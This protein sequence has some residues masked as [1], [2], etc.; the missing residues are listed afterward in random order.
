M[1]IHFSRRLVPSLVS[2]SLIISLL[3]PWPLQA[4]ARPQNEPPRA[5]LTQSTSDLPPYEEP[6]APDP[7]PEPLSAP[8]VDAPDREGIST[9]A[10]PEDSAE[11]RAP[12]PAPMKHG[13]LYFSQDSNTNGLYLVDTV[14]GAATLVGQSGVTASTVGLA[15]GPTDGTL[16]GSKWAGLL[17]IAR[18]GSGATL[19]GSVGMEGMAYLRGTLYASINFEFFTVDTTTGT[20]Y[21]TLAAPPFDAE[22]L[23]AD[24]ERNRVYGIGQDSDLLYY[25][26]VPSNAWYVVGSTGVPSVPGWD[27][28]ALAYDP[29]SRELY[30]ASSVMGGN[31]YRINPT[32]AARTLVGNMG[33][34][35]AGGGLAYVTAGQAYVAATWADDAVHI[36]DPGMRDLGKFNARVAD[37]NAVVT[38]GELVYTGHYTT[39]EVIATDFTGSE[40]FRWPVD[41]PG[42]AGM[43]LVDGTLAVL[44]QATPYQVGIYQ[45]RTG[46]LL[47]SY[48]ALPSVE[49]LAYDGTLL[50]QLGDLL[51]GTD[52]LDGHVVR[53]LPNAASGCSFGGTGLAAAPPGRLTLSCSNGNWYQISADTGVVLASGDNDLSIYGLDA[54]PPAY[55]AAHWAGDEVTGLD[56]YMQPL[57]RMSAGATEPNGAASDGR[58]VYTGH[59]ESEHIIGHDLAGTERVR[60]SAAL[61]GLQGMDMVYGALAIYRSL[62]EPVIQ[63]RRA[64]TGALLRTVPG[65]LSVEGLAFDGELLWQL[66]NANV[67][68]SRPSD[69]AVV[70]TVPNPAAACLFGGTALTSGPPGQLIAGCSDGRWFRFSSV[71]GTVLA[72][73]HLWPGMYGLATL[74]QPP[75]PVY[76][77]LVMR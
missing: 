71:N 30:A 16:Y 68:G 25:Y 61:D 62:S 51:Y 49:A 23:A 18:D 31:L 21:A 60:W 34:G 42:L 8:A 67:Y 58:L 10:L 70:R 35:T 4:A 19:T 38:D 32:T 22:G 57:W 13:F 6:L 14:T 29:V 48:A 64:D 11:P 2:L 76:L 37:P 72:T 77:P 33:I 47:R 54:I 9:E 1:A 41:L 52:P 75:G 50:W 59:H 27:G 17:T 3:L 12:V 20:R 46:A 15:A 56:R 43:A 63:F 40:L 74:R 36:L 45:P 26:D 73:G 65:Q 69:G 28:G 66:G 39:R 53:T 7:L 44:F 55:F 24:P 5:V